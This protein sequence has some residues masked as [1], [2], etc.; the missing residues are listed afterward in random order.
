LATRKK[1]KK[2]DATSMAARQREIAVSEF[3]SKNRHLLGF[4]NL[5]KALLTT[6][7][8]AV[9]NALDACEEAHIL[10]EIHVTVKELAETRFSVTIE[11]NGPGILKS[12]LP[13]IFAKLLY[14]SKFHRLK[15]SRGQQGIGIS[16]AVMYGQMT[17]GQPAVVISKTSQGK[18]A[19]KLK[20][21]ID[22]Q[23]NQPKVIDDVIIDNKHWNEKESGTAITITLEATYKGGKHGVASY[24]HQSALSNS[25]A[26]FVFTDPKG[27]VHDYPRVVNEL[28]KEPK[29]IKPHPHGVELGTLMHLL[30]ASRGKTVSK[31]LK[32]TFSRVSA[33]TAADICKTAKVKG[34]ASASKAG[35]NEAE[36]LYN[37]IQNTKLLAPSTDCVSPIGEEALIK[38][39]YWL[40]VEAQ[41]HQEEERKA[42]K[43]Q[44]DL[45][46]A[47]N[48]KEKEGDDAQEE[49]VV[50]KEG[51]NVQMELALA[52]D[53]TLASDEKGY[54]V[55]AVT[56]SP[57]VY[58]GNPFQ[59]EVGIFYGKGLAGD[60]QARV[61]RFAN[62]VP[63][64][65]QASACAM[66]K[67]VTSTRWKTYGLNQ[68]RG[69]LPIGP[70]VIMVHIAS[71]WVPYTSESKE[72]IANYD[73]ILKELRL[74]INECGRRLQKFL[75][76]KR[77]E[78]DEEK[79]RSYIIK[80][81]NPIGE[82]LQEILGFSDSQK[83][84]TISS[85]KEILEDARG[86]MP[87]GRSIK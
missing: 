42:Q 69:S 2:E 67:S 76:R 25:H 52:P 59:V 41:K 38:G 23:R 33:K 30:E 16:A 29:E 50:E 13:K 26:I 57:N 77:K 28:P 68:S 79:K 66:T 32:D 9:D 85:L 87:G 10:P 47:A 81:M 17:T 6:V 21:Q 19:H 80:Y 3:F 75:R 7:R 34:G 27:K 15:Q 1:Q 14:G 65:Y 82:A 40:F 61:F 58:R 73:E 71:A 78:A 11:D 44:Q 45:F 72:A 56:R 64:Q 70:V 54:F 53:G 51:G 22:T 8:E 48:D 83:D 31:F 12:Q 24:L 20:L 55:T 36:K 84:E 5:S 35:R 60:D 18:P 62:R 63:L 37:A 74:A 39:L 86:H 4:D 46:E 49:P 43:A